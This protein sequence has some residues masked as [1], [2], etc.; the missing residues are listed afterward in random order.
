MALK[1]E[2]N[3]AE[4]KISEISS[5]FTILWN[6]RLKKN[7]STSYFYDMYYY[8]EIRDFSVFKKELYFLHFKK[9]TAA[10]VQNWTYFF[11]QIT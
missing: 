4:K 1:I 10:N 3:S 7:S 2:K 6:Q 8:I 9:R 11:L 5:D